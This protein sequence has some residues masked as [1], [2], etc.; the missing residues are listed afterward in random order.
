L[1][2]ALSESPIG[3]VLGGPLN[4]A[5][6]GDNPEP[7]YPNKPFVD[8]TDRAAPPDE[9]P[10]DW[11]D[12]VEFKGEYLN[13]KVA[14]QKNPDDPLI[15]YD[16]AG[17][18]DKQGR[19]STALQELERAVQLAPDRM[20]FAN[21]YRMLVR[22]NGHVYFD[23]SIRFFEDLAEKY[24]DST[25]AR[26]NKALAYVDKMPYPKL[27]IVHEGIILSNKSLQV[28]DG[29]L[30]EDPKCWVAKFMRGMNHLHWPRILGHAPL[31]IVDFTELIAMQK[32]FPAEKQREWNQFALAYIALGDSYVKNRAT[33]L[34]ESLARARQV[35]QA[36]ITEYPDCPELKERLELIA[37]SEKE[38]VAYVEK[39]CG[40]EDPVDTDLAKVWFYTE[41]KP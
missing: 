25:M 36:G 7:H 38:L 20:R 32:T 23:R 33:G 41:A 17:L 15:H 37:Q 39:R 27:G 2:Q 35:W 10:Q 22:K 6:A 1:R 9:E 26:L 12:T 3:L 8:V 18:L 29:I 13:F 28:L 4:P 21:K 24:P 30:E 40:L 16:F 31:A 34:Q 5:S 11:P 14:I 19:R